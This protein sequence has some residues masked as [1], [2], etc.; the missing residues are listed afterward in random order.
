MHGCVAAIVS[1]VRNLSN[2]ANDR[3]IF[4]DFADLF[5]AERAPRPMFIL[6]GAKIDSLLSEI[7]TS[8]LLPKS[9]SANQQD[10]LLDGDSPLG[11]FSSRIKICHRL[12]LIDKTLYKTLD[13][14]RIIRNICA[15]DLTVECSISP[16]REHLA[17]LRRM[18]TVRKSYRLTKSRYFDG[19]V[20]QQH[21]DLQC[22][23]LTI[24]VLLE[25][26]RNDTIQTKG[27]PHTIKFSSR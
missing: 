26:V 21:D 10:E 4:D 9:A 16:M 17:D 7:L 23:I 24:C 22:L 8:Y 12:G 1:P 11:T 15:H 13:K 5:Q 2:V 6:G 18:V 14:L 3:T 25:G 20:R 27:Q 19:D